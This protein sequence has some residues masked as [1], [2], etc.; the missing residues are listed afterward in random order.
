MAD[1]GCLLQ[2]LT[3]HHN[4]PRWLDDQLDAIDAGH[5]VQIEPLADSATPYLSATIYT[6]SGTVTL[7]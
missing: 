7:T 3:I 1:T 4:R 5:L 2:E 6:P